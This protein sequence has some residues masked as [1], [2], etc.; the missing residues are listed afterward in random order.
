DG[1]RQRLCCLKLSR[2]TTARLLRTALDDSGWRS[3]AALDAATRLTAAIAR[4]GGVN[5][6]AQA[7]RTLELFFKNALVDEPEDALTIPQ[8]Y[9]LV[10][11]AESDANQEQLLL[12][13]AVLVRVRDARRLKT[14]AG[15]GS[16]ESNE[17]PS[18]LSPELMAALKE[19]PLR[20]MRELL[21]MFLADGIFAPMLLLIAIVL[22]AAG[23]I[24][25]ALVLRG[26]L[27]MGRELILS[28]QRLA[29]MGLLLLLLTALLLLDIPVAAIALKLGRKLEVRLRIAFLEK[30]PRLSDRYF[31]SRLASDMAERSHSIHRLRGLPDLG[32]QFLRA[33]FTLLFTVA[34]IAW[35]SPSSIFPVLLLAATSAV[36][37]PLVSQ[38]VLSERDLRARTHAGA[39]SRFYLDAFMGM[40]PIRTHNAEK[41]VRREHEG[42]LVEWTRAS[43]A[44]QRGVV[45]VE[46]IQMLSGFG[47]A[48]FLSYGYLQSGRLT[49]GAL[50]LIYWALSL[51]VL[52][53]EIAAVARLYPAYRSITLRILEPMGAAEET[54][55]TEGDSVESYVSADAGSVSVCGV[56]ID[57]EEVCVRAGGHTILEEI[58]LSFEGGS[59]TAIVGPSGAG[60]SSLVG[61]LLGWHKPATGRVVVNG[62]ALDGDRLDKLRQETAWVDP[63]VQ[64]WNRSLIE[65]LR[66]GTKDIPSTLGR[67]IEAAELGDLLERLP[68]G[69]QTNL[70]EGGALVSGG[71]GQRVRLGRAMLRPNVRLVILDEPFRGL[72]REHRR[73]LLARARELWKEATLLCVTHD[74]GETRAFGR[75]LVVEGGR[76]VEDGSPVDLARAPASRYRNL[77]DAEEAVRAGLWA[78]VTWRRLRL[79]RGR[80][81]ET[82]GDI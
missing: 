17:T 65:N 69:L 5:P 19:R 7:A 51:P 66:Y 73:E 80:L 3:L 46:A 72:D 26:L 1:L 15:V 40:I 45:A 11:A 68:D 56:S 24:V 54:V 59:H 8:P 18:P 39:L 2:G 77:L 48:A 32:C 41:I 61:L 67:T 47:F 30:L 43:V 81:S 63:A 16:D 13:G 74:I 38:P 70:G 9:W 29:A 42:L 20:P 31:H 44:L 14:G 23:V 62:L 36:A 37:L 6:G 10:R 57:M 12:R 78:D 60:K 4:S 75:V 71:E 25:E 22:A 58:N 27:D 76:V 33:S 52:G 79:E 28:R 49:G 55:S 82:R 50:L 21:R 64:L 35:L 34:A 53:Q